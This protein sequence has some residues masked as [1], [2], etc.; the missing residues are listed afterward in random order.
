M[1][2]EV[3]TAE[4]AK[5]GDSEV[6]STDTAAVHGARSGHCL[7]GSI[8]YR[9]EA[10]P[11][12]VVLCHCDDCQRHSGAAF[13]V[14][15][16]VARDAVKIEGTPRSHQTTG[17]ENGELRDRLFCGDCGTPIFTILHEL[18]DIMIVKAGTLD[19]RTGLE[20]S[21]DVWWRRAQDWIEPHPTRPRFDGDAK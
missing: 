18:P 11:E 2:T 13:S 1:P 16:L 9:F 5:E 3:N 14:N 12:T 7:C 17:S 21:A 10:Q 8:S 15:V 19:D 20:P 4:Q 6:N